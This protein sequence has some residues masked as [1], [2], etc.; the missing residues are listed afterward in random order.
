[1]RVA[2]YPGSF[3]PITNGH[4]DI[5]RRAAGIF[6]KVIIAIT[7]NSKKQSLFS[8]EERIELTNQVL[9]DSKLDRKRILVESFTGLT[10]DFCKQKKASAIIRGLRAVTDFDYESA[11]SLMN[12]KLDSDV[13]TI[14]LISSAEYSF[15][16]SSIVKEVAKHGRSVSGH[17]H[18][19]INLALLEKFKQSK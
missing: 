3:D 17:V 6:D 18:E 14:F 12:Q 10:I 8:I 11:I 9:V 19:K 13:E 7:S 16:S 1:M 5:A 2:V 15:I 4:L